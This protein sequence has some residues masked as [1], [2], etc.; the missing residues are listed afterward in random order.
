[1]A[2]HYVGVA[3]LVRLPGKSGLSL[4]F[5]W[6]S[7]LV[8][9]RGAD[10]HVELQYGQSAALCIR[11][12]HKDQGL[13]SLPIGGQ[14][15]ATPTIISVVSVVVVVVVLCVLH[16]LALTTIPI[17]AIVAHYLD[18]VVKLRFRHIQ[19]VIITSWAVG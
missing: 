2:G 13:T 6:N 8:S 19:P 16:S 15:I 3:L 9:K 12:G 14:W 10:G 1:M 18:C 4:G 11:K 17:L 5:L 7:G